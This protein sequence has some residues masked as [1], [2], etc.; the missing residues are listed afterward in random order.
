MTQEDE[1]AG[2]LAIP[3]ENEF[4]FNMVGLSKMSFIV[5]DH[6]ITAGQAGTWGGITKIVCGDKGCTLTVKAGRKGSSDVAVWFKAAIKPGS[7]IGCGTF[8]TLPEKLNFAL[9]GTLSFDHKDRHYVGEK[10]V[11]AQGHNAR[12]RNNW[13]IGG[14]NMSQITNIPIVHLGAAAQT[15][16]YTNIISIPAKVTFVTFLEQISSM[17]LGVVDL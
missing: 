4:T 3:R 8:D 1:D 10:I 17:N 5:T 16:H 9:T 13:W 6:C 14:P 7:A 11:L 15:F 12:S 2:A